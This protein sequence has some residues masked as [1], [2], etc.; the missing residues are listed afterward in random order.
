M[1]PVVVMTGPPL[2]RLVVPDPS[3]PIYSKRQ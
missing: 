1:V 3:S 2:S